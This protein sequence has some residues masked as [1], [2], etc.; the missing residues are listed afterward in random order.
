MELSLLMDCGDKRGYNV[1][2]S[3][4]MLHVCFLKSWSCGIILEQLLIRILRRVYVC[5]GTL[6]L[7]GAHRKEME[8]ECWL[9]SEIWR[10]SMVLLE[11]AT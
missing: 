3:M 11:I 6:M 5:W 9:T 8:G 7:F 1:I 2:L 10:N 4:F